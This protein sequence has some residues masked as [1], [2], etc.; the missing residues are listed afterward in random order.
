MP[1]HVKTVVKFKNLKEK[2]KDFIK[3]MI[4]RPLTEKDTLFR[5]DRPSWIID[6]DKIIPEPR[7]KEDCP[8]GCLITEKSHVVIEDDR[9]WFNWYEWHLAYWGTKWNAYDGYT[10]EG[11][12]YLTFVFSTAWSVATP[13]ITKLHLLGYDIDVKYADEDLGINCGTMEYRKEDRSW[14][15]DC[16]DLPNPYSFAKRLWD[17]Y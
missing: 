15:T 11:K 7:S 5:A 3:E 17:R 14:D 4:A 16:G 2:D 12:S 9:P 10:E 1:N 6:F 13:V 8:A